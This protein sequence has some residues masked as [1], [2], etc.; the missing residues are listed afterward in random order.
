MP[1]DPDLR[2][3]ITGVTGVLGRRVLGAIAADATVAEVVAIDVKPVPAPHRGAPRVR[4]VRA[5]LRHAELTTHLDGV[6]TLVHLA[7]SSR[8]EVDEE[9]ARSVNV[10]A[11]ARVLEAADRSGVGTV[12][13]VSSAMVYGARA[14]NP[15]P[16]TEE[17]PVQPEP[18]LAYAM[19]KAEVERL[20]L[21]WADGAGG[22]RA[23]VLRSAAAL[24]AD[25]AS[26]VARSLAA[27][28]RVPR[29][30]DVEPP[31]QFVHL[32]DLTSAVALV[33][34]DARASGPLNVAADGWMPGEM[35]RALTGAPPRIS[36]P[37]SV[38]ATLASWSWRLQLGPLP[39][40]LVPYTMHPWVVANDRLRS[41]GWSPRWTN[42]EAFV[43]GTEGSWWSM[44]TPKRR[45]ELA[46]GSAGVA[47]TSVVVAGGLVA[48]RLVERA[49][50]LSG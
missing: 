49:R 9:S 28:A 46:L 31:A 38:A 21:A 1:G 14:A 12:V 23:V 43:E 8:T 40:G 33:S 35:V 26:Y 2:V 7:S 39:P 19:Q 27:A 45:Q 41:L 18:D 20:V 6:A 22:R 44:L 42:E 16:L 25:G 11:T 36:L 17:A 37:P 10:D 3:A 4:A 34:A 48:R 13:V 47:A 24:A 15:V 32:D 50:S 29:A 5:D 30:G